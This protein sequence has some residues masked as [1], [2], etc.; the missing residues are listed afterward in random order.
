M[1]HAGLGV[2]DTTTDD[3]FSI[4][5]VSNNYVGGL[6][7]NTSNGYINWLNSGSIVIT[8][9]LD[10][11]AWL[12]SRLL[13]TTSGS[14]YSQLITYLQG[15]T[16]LFQYYQPVTALYVNTSLIN[17]SIAI[18]NDDIDNIGTVLVQPTNSFA[19]VDDLIIQLGSYGCDLGA[20]LQIYATSFGYLTR[21]KAAPNVVSWGEGQPA[22]ADV[23]RWY[24]DL[25]KCYKNAYSATQKSGADASFFLGVSVAVYPSYLM[26]IVIVVGL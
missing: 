26:V 3:K 12:N 6:L 2:W 22:N 18:T 1:A 25:N 15:N 20:F 19:F 10:S 17:A 23:Y 9:P 13:T 8:D 21:E 11:E 16:G 14:A 4:E 5:F 7:P 24:S